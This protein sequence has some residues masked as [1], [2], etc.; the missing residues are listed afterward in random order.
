MSITLSTHNAIGA[1][2]VTALTR[3]MQMHV[4]D[5]RVVQTCVQPRC[6]VFACTHLGGHQMM[7]MIVGP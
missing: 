2:R 3:V 1:A 7:A 6:D 4:G 5:L